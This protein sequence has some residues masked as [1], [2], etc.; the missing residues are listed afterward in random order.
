M[1]RLRL[2]GRS[3][4]PPR[5]AALRLLAPAALLAAITV[6]VLLVR[7]SLQG[8]G[9][10]AEPARATQGAPASRAR[11][12]RPAAPRFHAVRSGDTLGSIARRYETTVGRLL[13]LNPGVEPTALAIGQRLR[14]A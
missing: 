8:N 13:T 3:E 11:P 7:T 2:V 12:E 9:A 6:A 14:V 1:G 5:P 4:R 10:A